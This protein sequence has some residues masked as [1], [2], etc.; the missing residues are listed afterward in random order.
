MF[1]K[2]IKTSRSI[3]NNPTTCARYDEVCDK[4]VII[5]TECACYISL[6][7]MYVCMDEPASRE[8]YLQYMRIGVQFV[9]KHTLAHF[10]DIV[11]FICVLYSV[12]LTNISYRIAKT[13]FINR[14]R[15]SLT[16]L[17]IH[18]PKRFQWYF[19]YVLHVCYYTKGDVNTD[20]L[21]YRYYQQN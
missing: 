8:Q 14:L 15:I 1:V 16:D 21:M 7:P 12:I 10:F 20:T 9:R 17:F 6:I 11:C 13:D 2:E 3:T 19:N 5:Q 18:C 4:H